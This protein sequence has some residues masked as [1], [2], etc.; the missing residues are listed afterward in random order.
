LG[1]D[2]NHHNP[3]D[4]EITM[5]QVFPEAI[6]NLPEANLPFQG[7]KG[8]I[9]QALNHQII[10]MEF[11]ENVDVPA[12]SHAAQLGIVLEGKIDLLINGDLRSFTKGDRYYI[13]EGTVHS[14]K[15]YAGYADV[16]FF[17]EPDRYH[18]K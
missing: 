12:H 3:I 18:C 15:I 16:T 17:N 13:P 5:S 7:V 14:A 9:S 6:T 4:G 8:Y 10:F 11:S 1:I 2:Y